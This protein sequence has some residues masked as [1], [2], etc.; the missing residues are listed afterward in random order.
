MLIENYFWLDYITPSSLNDQT[1]E[2]SSQLKYPILNP[3]SLKPR[4]IIISDQF[5]SDASSLCEY[6]KITELSPGMTVNITL[7]EILKI[8][9]RKRPRI[10]SYNTLV[11]YLKEQI[12]VELIISSNKTKNLDK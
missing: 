9:P 6:A 2:D 4:K 1:V 7:Q 11:R 5:K 12:G 8:I 10:D 3:E